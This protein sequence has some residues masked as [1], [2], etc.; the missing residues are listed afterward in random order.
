MRIAR[1]LAVPT[2]GGY[3]N[4]DLAAIRAGAK[5]DGF[6]YVGTPLTPGFETIRHPTEAASIIL[7]LDD[8]EVVVGDALTVQYAGAGGRTR[9]FTHREQLPALREVCAYLESL[10][11]TDFVGMCEALE[12]QRFAEPALNRTA[13][14]YG[15]SQALLLAV[16]AARRLT[17][18]EALAEACGTTVVTQ[19]IPIYVQCGEDRRNGVDRGILHQ[20]DVLPHGLINTVEVLGGRGEKLQEYVTWIARRVRELG[21]PAYAPELHIDTYGLL[22]TI[23]A[24]DPKRIAEYI[25]D[26]AERARP[27]RFCLET[28]V[29][30]DSRTAQ[31]DLFG[32]IRAE[33]RRL[34]SQAQLIVDEWAND[35]EDIRAFIQAGATDMVNVK[36]P[37]LGSLHH[38][39]QAILESWAAGVR[40]ILGGSSNDSDQSARVIAHVALATRPAW[41]LARPGMGMDEG[42]QIV[43]NEMR[44]TLAIVEARRA[45]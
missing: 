20:A 6:T 40:P 25:A 35:L 8:G 16:A 34:G 31:I 27:W 45:T 32:R 44:R 42:F 15:V 5:R 21:R 10:E 23:F 37:D 7:I 13:A 17:P 28:P 2:W 36:S 12:A 22:G 9:R 19:L 4:D 18:A 41:V 33:L 43:H 39:A 29:L 3:F 26:L 11:I 24:D 1:A 30:A 38:T 14:Y